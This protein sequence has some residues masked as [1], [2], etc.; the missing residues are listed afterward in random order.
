MMKINDEFIKNNNERILLSISRILEP[1]QSDSVSGKDETG[2]IKDNTISEEEQALIWDV[3]NRPYISKTE[4]Y[5]TINIDNKP[6]SAGK[7]TR[8]SDSLIRQNLVKEHEINLGGRGGNAKFFE[9]TNKGYKVIGMEPKKGIGRGAD[10]EHGFWQYYVREKTSLMKVVTKATIEG[11]INNK[12]VDILV[13]TMDEKV[14]IEVAM[15]PD[16]EKVNMEKDLGA[17]CNMVFVG[18][19]NKSVLT[20]VE[21]IAK[22]FSDN[23]KNRLTVCRIQKLIGNVENYLSEKGG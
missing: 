23:V 9:L 7:G 16:H 13:E 8:I 11:R 10:F 1:Q 5:N 14:A 20:A 18:C 19:G 4:R 22:S 3:F 15:T 6:I 21:R 2:N 12:Y 17:G